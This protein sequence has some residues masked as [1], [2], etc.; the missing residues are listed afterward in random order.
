MTGRSLIRPASR[1]R[2]SAPFPAR[3]EP[4]TRD[5]AGGPAERHA[6]RGEAV[7]MSGCSL[8]RWR[9]IPT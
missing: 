2:A 1:D 6:L 4:P 9:S 7:V 3:P 8:R 5:A